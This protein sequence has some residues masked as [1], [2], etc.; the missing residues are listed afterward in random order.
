MRLNTLTLIL[1]ITSITLALAHYG[2]KDANR[3][4]HIQPRADND[5]FPI[6][7]IF[8][9]PPPSISSLV[10]SGNL[11]LAAC[12]TTSNAF[13]LYAAGTIPNCAATLPTQ[14][15]SWVS[16]V[17]NSVLSSLTAGP[18]AVMSALVKHFPPLAEVVSDNPVLTGGTCLMTASATVTATATGKMQT[19]KS[20]PTATATKT[21]TASSAT[22]TAKN[23]IAA[24]AIEAPA[25]AAGLAGALVVAS[26]GFVAAL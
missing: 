14:A 21:K 3:I 26:L 10:P 11:N 4:H 1:F 24:G 6:K 22:A 20:T 25:A 5:A 12:L 7:D 15:Q 2:P 23:N 8:P 13:C 9:T 18:V 19:P 16:S 17:G